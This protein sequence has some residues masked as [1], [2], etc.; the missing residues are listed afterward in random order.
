[1]CKRDLP[2]TIPILQLGRVNHAGRY[3]ISS[4]NE[5]EARM[6]NSI[7]QKASLAA[8]AVLLVGLQA[9]YADDLIKVRF[10]TNWLAE[11]EHGGYYQAV[12]D[13]TY[14]KYGLDVEIVQGGPQA[15]NATALVAGKIDFNMNGNMVELFSAV[16]QGVPI[17][18]V[19]A[20]FQKDPQILMSHPGVG[21]DTWADLKKSKSILMGPDFQASDFAWMKSAFGYTDD[22]VKP[23]DFNPGPFIADTMSV[24][25]GYVTSE[26]FSAEKGGGF[27]PNVFLLA[28]QGWNTYSTLITTRQ[29]VVDKKSDLVQKFVDA[30]AIGWINYLNGYNM[31][32]NE[33]IK[34]DN[35][36]MT[37]ELIAYGIKQLKD[38]GLVLSGDAKKG[39]VGSMTD[40]HMKSFFEK[41]VAAGV[42]KADLD[43]KKAY[44]LKFV[45][46]NVGDDLLKK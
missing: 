39:G 15:N 27:K 45:N 20:S 3:G 21:L 4:R 40:E 41:M 6:T 42:F 32:A 2:I 24:Q 10:G 38:H 17:V 7:L 31:A 9:T 28:D 19:A 22:Q 46:K 33:A 34:K 14:K 1:L 16:Q 30:S 8:M 35:P 43:Y 12:A 44:T 26:P 5:T 11:P 25:Q 23:Y 18:T 36:D 13:G 29:E 37:D